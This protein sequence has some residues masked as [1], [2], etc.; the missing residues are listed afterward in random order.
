[1]LPRLAV[2]L[3]MAHPTRTWPGWGALLALAALC[4]ALLV[5]LHQSWWRPMRP[6]RRWVWGPLIATTV[7]LLCLAFGR[8]AA[9]GPLSDRLALTPPSATPAAP[10]SGA[11]VTATGDAPS[12]S[13]VPRAAFD[14]GARAGNAATP[15]ARIDAGPSVPVVTAND[16]PEDTRP[17]GEPSEGTRA[18]QGA[19]AA[20]PSPLGNLTLAAPTDTQTASSASTSNSTTSPGS[21]G[22]N[23]GLSGV[24][25]LGTNGGLGANGLA[26]SSG[27]P[28]I[29]GWNTDATSAS[30]A[31]ALPSGTLGASGA[32]S[33]SGGASARGALDTHASG[34]AHTGGATG[35]SGAPSPSV[36][37][38]AGGAPSSSSGPNPSAAANA[39]GDPRETMK[40]E[41][42]AHARRAGTLDVVRAIEGLL[43]AYPETTTD[44]DVHRALIRAA[45]SGGAASRAAL[46]LMSTSM[47][48]AGPDLLY[49]LMVERPS[50]AEQ[51]KYLLSRTRVRKLFSPQLAIAYDLRFSPSCN[52]RLGLLDRANDIGDQRS[53]NTLASLLNNSPRCGQPGRF[54]C[55][56]LCE[57]ESPQFTK[58]IDTMVRR[59]RTSERAASMN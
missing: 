57:R 16:L 9:L 59:L 24:G 54:P 55:I 36:G 38:S 7:V 45:A 52:A 18:P 3:N 56:E 1:V 51:T 31:P 39:S 30:G 58:A 40:A 26:P 46:N 34:S 50:L 8:W 41:V 21:S 11:T 47:G 13:H 33:P 27:S 5:V 35:A 22:A 2:D 29:R 12:T 48:S 42:L 49:Q 44:P 43:L 37:A 25:G 14:G 10:P 17:L 23:G 32:P 53:I 20:T 4:T 28:A 19:E 15:L 6:A